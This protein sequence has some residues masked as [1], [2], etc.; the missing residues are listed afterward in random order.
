MFA[1]KIIKNASW[2]IGCKI[3]Q[4]IIGLVVAMLTARYLGPSN[5]GVINYAAS[6]VAFVTPIMQLGLNDVMVQEMV[7]EP[8]KEGIILGSSILM[9]ITSALFCALGVFVTASFLNAGE[10]ETIIVCILY[11]SI[12][13]FQAVELTQYWFQAKYLS[14]YTS[15]AAFTAYISVAAY[16]IFLLITG[17]S[18]YWFAVSNSLEACLIALL[19]FIL[20]KKN[21]GKRLQFSLTIAK[22]LFAKS[23]FYIVSSMMVVVFAQTDRIMIKNM[24][25]NAE[26]GF[27]S[28]AVTCAALTNFVFGAIIDS[29]RPLIFEKKKNGGR[30]YENSMSSLYS[31]VIYLALIQSFIMTI[32]AP[33][34][35]KIMYGAAYTPSIAALQIIVWYTTFSYIGTIRNIWILAESKQKYL[36]II[37]LMGVIANIALNFVLIPL[38]G[39]NGAALASLITQFFTNIITSCIIKPIRFNNILIFRSLNPRYLKQILQVARKSS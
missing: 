18:I 16:K 26:T 23:H 8:Q 19:F 27:Y 13:I 4:S 12:L 37:N 32:F 30:E 38:W 31:I 21:G 22:R 17:K 36:W 25:G 6:M 29:F 24:L 35:I 20:Y 9:S 15:L 3:L 33:I 5:F 34:I 1:N 11:S 28:A 39:I 10:N 2:I 7:D 14:K